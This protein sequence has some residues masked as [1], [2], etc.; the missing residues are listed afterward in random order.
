MDI[1]RR[2]VDRNNGAL[3]FTSQPGHTVFRVRLPVA[4]TKAL[5]LG[6]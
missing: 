4:G 2:F 3:D 5:V 6:S 1:A